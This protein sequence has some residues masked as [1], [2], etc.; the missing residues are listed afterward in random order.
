MGP[1]S[2]SKALNREETIQQTKTSLQQQQTLIHG[3]IEE[4]NG[5]HQDIS[6][7]LSLVKS[8]CEPCVQK[9]CP[10]SCTY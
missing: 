5:I 3:K 8:V 2:K 7:R 1:Y 9:A 10:D 6:K 4:L